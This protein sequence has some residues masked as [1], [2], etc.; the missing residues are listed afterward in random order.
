MSQRK[1]PPLALAKLQ[2]QTS[3]W[4]QVFGR[5]LDESPDVAKTIRSAIERS[6]GIVLNLTLKAGEFFGDDVGEVRDNPIE[7]FGHGRKQICLKEIDLDR[8]PDTVLASEAKSFKRNIGCPDDGTREFQSQR[9]R[10]DSRT[11]ANIKYAD[12]LWALASC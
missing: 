10:D 1:R 7:S 6:R 4:R 9:N 11:G 2:S 8:V 5:G 3:G 12:V